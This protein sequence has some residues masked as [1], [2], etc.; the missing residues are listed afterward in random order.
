MSRALLLA[1]VLV[2]GLGLVAAADEL[3]AAETEAVRFVD[4]IPSGPSVAERLVEIRRRIGAALVYP[5]LARLDRIEGEALIR[6]E[7]SRDGSAREVQLF[8]TS[9]K[10]SL[11]RAAMRAVVDAAP[12]PWVHGKLEVP[13]RF[14]LKPRGPGGARAAAVAAQR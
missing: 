1:A 4:A 5:P 10:P 13:V 11:D 12:L 8:R 6:F 14:E 2:A 7:I 3:A 9:G